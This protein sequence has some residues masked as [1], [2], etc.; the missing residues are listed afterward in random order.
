MDGR[1]QIPVIRYLQD[2]FG[3]DY[4]DVISEAGPNRILAEGCNAAAVESIERRIRISLEHHHSVGIAVIGHH[5]CAG[6]P[7]SRSE[8]RQHTAAAVFSLQRRFGHIPV[9][10]LWVDEHWEVSELK[11]EDVSADKAP[12]DHA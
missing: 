10:G 2:R 5:D 1:V 12:R 8:Q 7:S 11:P 4:V 9:I 6:N 3:A